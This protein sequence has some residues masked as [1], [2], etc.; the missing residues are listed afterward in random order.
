MSFIKKSF[1]YFSS[2][3]F[4]FFDYIIKTWVFINDFFFFFFLAMLCG[5][6][7]PNSLT[8]D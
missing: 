2:R 6:H 8:K 7:D 1:A 3:L 5:L 4:I